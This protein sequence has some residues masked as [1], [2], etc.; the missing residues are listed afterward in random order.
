MVE[1]KPKGESKNIITGRPGPRVFPI[2]IGLGVTAAFGIPMYLHGVNHENFLRRPL[3]A[4]EGAVVDERY[5]QPTD[6]LG[7]EG[8]GYF[9]SLDT[10][11]REVVSIEVMDSYKSSSYRD[12]K[13]ETIDARV[14]G[15]AVVQV[16]ARE[17]APQV[18]KAFADEINVSK[19]ST[20]F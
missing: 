16:R 6:G 3:V 2:I 19:V 11:A 1:D 7:G 12:I 15:G 5:V 14:S 17:I 8:S 4:L 18:Y 10:S 9:F 20:R 13:K